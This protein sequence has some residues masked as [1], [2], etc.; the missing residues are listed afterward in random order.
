[1][2]A[3]TR[4]ERKTTEERLMSGMLTTISRE[5]EAS[6]SGLVAPPKPL[7]A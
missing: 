6:L 7:D 3:P 4:K 1:M 2:K 5:E